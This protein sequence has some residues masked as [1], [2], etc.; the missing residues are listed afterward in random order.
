MYLVCTIS[1]Q[2]C[3]AV[4]AS[5]SAGAA[6]AVGSL[7]NAKVADGVVDHHCARAQACGNRL[8][9][10]GVARPHACRK[11]ESRII[12]ARDGFFRVFHRL[13][14]ENRT[15]GLFLKKFH[16]GIYAGND[17]RLEEIRA[18]VRAR[19]SAAQD[20]SAPRHRI[21]NQI[22]HAL[23]MLRTNQRTNIGCRIASRTEPQFFRFFDAQRKKLFLD[24][25][26]HKKPLDG[27]ANLPA[28][29]VAAPNGGA[30]GNFEVRIGKNNHRVLAAKFE[31][32]RN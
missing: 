22:A 30:R 4:G 31:H 21:G 17:G 12:R 14:G 5:P 32:A 26:F 23:H 6:A 28:I 25:L 18:K 13:H 20:A 7:R 11:R 2:A 29:R 9:A 27:K 24:G 3:F 15:E 10:F 19:F 1:Q 16:R 8:A